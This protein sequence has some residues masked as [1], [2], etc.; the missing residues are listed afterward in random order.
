MASSRLIIVPQYPAFL[1]YQS[2]WLERLAEYHHYFDE[3]L[4]IAP[5]IE[6]AVVPKGFF[7]PLDAAL[8]YETAQIEYYVKKVIL[9]PD[10]ALLLCDISY[11]GL[12]ANVL[13]HKRPKRCFAICH[14]SALNRFD[15]FAGDRWAKRPVENGVSRLFDTVFVASEYHKRKLCWPNVTVI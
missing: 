10:D 4:L 14:G 12:F 3:V 8:R 5:P 11:P 2:W 1:R 7:A 6:E 9:R 13:F 15:I